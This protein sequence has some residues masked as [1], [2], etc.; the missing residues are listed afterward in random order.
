MLL[1]SVYTKC[2]VGVIDTGEQLIAGV[3]DTGD[4]NKVSNI[5]TNFCEKDTQ[6]PE[7]NSGTRGS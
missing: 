4:K 2:I 5:Y 6:G 7:G 3:N 1:D